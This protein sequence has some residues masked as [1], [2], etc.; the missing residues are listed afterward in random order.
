MYIKLK[1]NW[2][3]DLYTSPIQ[4]K[5]VLYMTA[6]DGDKLCHDLFWSA[7]QDPVILRS[8]CLKWTFILRLCFPGNIL[9]KLSTS[10]ALEH[11]LRLLPFLWWYH[12]VNVNTLIDYRLNFHPRGMQEKA[13]SSRKT[14]EP[15]A[16]LHTRPWNMQYIKPISHMHCN[17][18]FMKIS[19]K[20]VWA[21][22]SIFSQQI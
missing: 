6:G 8:C 7:S 19:G 15:W 14:H 13:A 2:F 9:C 17:H 10:F 3:Q 12:I 5:H 20:A 11:F 4:D 22:I 1:S 18:N 16:M 21:P